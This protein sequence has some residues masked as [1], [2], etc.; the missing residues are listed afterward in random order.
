MTAVLELKDP[1]HNSIQHVPEVFKLIIIHSRAF[2]IPFGVVAPSQFHVI[3]PAP[4]A[5]RALV[6][7]LCCLSQCHAQGIFPPRSFSHALE[8]SISPSPLAPL[9]T[10]LGIP[11]PNSCNNARVSLWSIFASVQTFGWGEKLRVL[12]SEEKMFFTTLFC[13]G[14]SKHVP[15]PRGGCCLARHISG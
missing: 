11:T 15:S 4:D 9:F 5:E 8:D 10:R 6:F 2:I 7:A 14:S 3:L 13:S 12:W 1:R